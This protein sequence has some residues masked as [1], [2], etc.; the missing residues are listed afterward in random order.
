MRL[1]LLA[2]L[3]SWPTHLAWGEIAKPDQKNHYFRQEAGNNAAV[4]L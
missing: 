1:H 4:C 2:A 3:G